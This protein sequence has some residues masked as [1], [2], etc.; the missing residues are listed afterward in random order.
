MCKKCVVHELHKQRSIIKCMLKRQKRLEDK[1]DELYSII[2]ISNMGDVTIG[3]DVN[4][5]NNIYVDN[6]GSVTQPINNMYTVNGNAENFDKRGICLDDQTAAFDPSFAEFPREWI[7]T[8]LT[9][10]SVRTYSYTSES[11]DR[12]WVKWLLQNKIHVMVG[13]TL[14]TYKEELDTLSQDYATSETMYD[15]YVLALA[16]GNEQSVDKLEQIQAGI[17]YAKLLISQGKL[18]ETKVTSVLKDDS[19]WILNTYSPS[20]AVFTNS[21]TQLVPYLDIICF[22]MYDAYYAPANV[23]V[24]TKLSWISDESDKS[25]TLNGFGAVRYAMSKQSYN[26]PFWCTEVGWQWP[27]VSD[28]NPS[29]SQQ[30]LKTFYN[31]FLGFDMSASFLPEQ[32][33]SIVNPPDRIFYFTI[34]NVSTMS[35]TFGLY[36]KDSGLF[37]KL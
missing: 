13:I 6:I 8:T 15:T 30:N 5:V 10:Q 24:S 27:A 32:C 19:D 21:F 2:H 33:L 20:Q 12:I 3:S 23:P 25:V 31:N 7:K 26:K 4:P 29:N 37:P 17:N 28:N 9:I 35:K 1:I 11:R 22:N 14:E 36:I 34:R 18:P 16:V